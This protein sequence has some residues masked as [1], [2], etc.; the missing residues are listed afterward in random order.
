[1]IAGER[2]ADIVRA[3]EAAG[4]R[5]TQQTVV[6]R[7][8]LGLIQ[9]PRHRGL[10]RGRGSESIYPWGTGAQL[11]A[12]ERLVQRFGPDYERVGWALWIE[13][14]PV[15]SRYWRVPLEEACCN[16]N[17]AIRCFSDRSE[18]GKPLLSDVLI[19]AIEEIPR[20][21]NKLGVTGLLRRML[22][23]AAFG[24][25]LRALM[26]VAIGTYI[27]SHLQFEEDAKQEFV[28]GRMLG[29]IPAK[30]KRKQTTRELG[31]IELKEFEHMLKLLGRK[32]S[33]LKRNELATISEH[34]VV[35][36]RNELTCLVDL[37]CSIE[38]VQRMAYGSSSLPL[39]LLAAIVRD[40]NVTRHAHLLLFWIVARRIP[41]VGRGA[42][43]FLDQIYRP[44]SLALSADPT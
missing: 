13:G 14:R 21:R 40:L 26:E 43:Q 35:E 2:N 1:M 42:K 22:H 31:A 7:H 6:Q 38:Q 27:P 4:L 15:A 17:D 36:A 30:K 20:R 18:G 32:I 11:I 34:E 12:A 24:T 10:G 33:K 8:R 19:D 3:V 37:F 25:L 9:R 41:A 23:Q 5:I 39:R 44:A 28:M 16:F 29:A